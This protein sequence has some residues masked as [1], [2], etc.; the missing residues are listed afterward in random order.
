MQSIAAEAASELEGLIPSVAP[1]TRASGEYSVTIS[2]SSAE[3]AALRPEWEELERL[4]D[5]ASVFQSFAQISIWSRHFL[6]GPQVHGRLHVAMVREAGRPVLILP[7][8]VSRGGP[9]KLARIA[10]DPIAQYSEILLDPARADRAAFEAALASVKAAG[11]DAIILRRVRAESRLL[12]FAAGKLRPGTGQDAAP[13]ADISAFA[14]Y[15][16]YL[17]SLSKNMRKG[18]RNRKHHL[19]A[20]GEAQ[21]EVL[22]GGPEARRVL[23]DA[24]GLKRQWLI[25][26]GALSAAF[27]DPNTKECLLD[28]AEDGEG[29]GSIVTRLVVNGELAAIR[30]G[31]EHQGTYFAYISA[32]DQKFA[33]LSP[34]KMVMEF[35]MSQAHQRGLRR[36]D[37]L[38]PA[39]RHK[40]D[41]CPGEMQVADYTLPLTAAGL[42]YAGFYQERLR[43]A[44]RRAWYRLPTAIRS[45]AASRI[46]DI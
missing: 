4:S 43:P 31:F 45:R 29:A 44:L 8:V 14:D 26:R 39:D 3:L 30:F 25:Q 9:M 18:L 7:L 2:R 19:D 20:K 42:L 28:L 15:D 11:V 22:A 40:S 41:W 10:G 34:G 38:P 24:M 36:I 13:F 6:A 1:R 23:A 17:R 33:E 16:A 12:S 35:Y 37:M 5:P 27:L 32:Y 21:F 46:V